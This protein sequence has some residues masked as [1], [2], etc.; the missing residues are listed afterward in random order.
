MKKYLIFLLLSLLIFTTSCKKEKVTFI[1]SSK[2]SCYEDINSSS[3][4]LYLNIYTSANILNLSLKEHKN[5]ENSDIV[6][7]TITKYI[8]NNVEVDSVFYQFKITFFPHQASITHLTFINNLD[9]YEVEIGKYQLVKMPL[10]DSLITGVV[11]IND[12]NIVIYIH[13]GL[14]R[15]IYLTRVSTYLINHELIKIK[16]HIISDSYI[17]EG[18]TRFFTN[19]TINIPTELLVVSGMLKIEFTTNIKDYVIYVYYSYNKAQ[20]VIKVKEATFKV[21]SYL[22]SYFLY[23]SNKCLLSVTSTLVPF[24]VYSV[25]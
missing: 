24:S 2:V 25:L 10:N 20:E 23:N 3:R 5:I 19:V 9:S 12:N 13:N 16:K 6:F 22:V 4:T 21:A 8:Y 15:T 11:D 14:D 18:S 17:Y 1:E 7:K